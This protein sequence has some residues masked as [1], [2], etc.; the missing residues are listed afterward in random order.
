M[1]WG[2]CVAKVYVRPHAA[3]AALAKDRL[4]CELVK[5]MC[6]CLWD[7]ELWWRSFVK[8][9]GIEKRGCWPV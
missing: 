7:T 6:A 4:V 8:M 1:R 3:R 9:L 5:T 2:V